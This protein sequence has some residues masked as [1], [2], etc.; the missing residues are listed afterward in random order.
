MIL[1]CVDRIEGFRALASCP[2]Y[3]IV[4]RSIDN[5]GHLAM[6]YPA[7]LPPDD[8]SSVLAITRSLLNMMLIQGISRST[9]ADIAVRTPLR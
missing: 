3:S 9:I 2:S 5:D 7:S 1:L 8:E 6:S 4:H